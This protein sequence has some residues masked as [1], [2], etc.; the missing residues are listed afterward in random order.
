MF[1]QLTH[2]S[3]TRQGFN[4]R[5]PTITKKQTDHNTSPGKPECEAI[6]DIIL[7]TLEPD[8]GG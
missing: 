1:P 3:E 2:I 4:D 6:L 5:N 8:Y 7:T